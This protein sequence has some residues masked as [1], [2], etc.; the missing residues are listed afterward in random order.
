MSKTTRI[1]PIICLLLNVMLIYSSERSWANQSHQDIILGELNSSSKSF[2]IPNGISS[3]KISLTEAN[4]SA[5]S[6]TIPE[7]VKN[8]TLDIRGLNHS[9]IYLYMHHTPVITRNI[10][11]SNNSCVSELHPLRKYTYHVLS[12][13]TLAAAAWWFSSKSD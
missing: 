2:C 13:A 12:L 5:I 11:E 10:K 1:L 6:V 9:G 8:V 4:N 7:S 3:I